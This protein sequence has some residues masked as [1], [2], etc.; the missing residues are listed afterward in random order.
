MRYAVG[1][2]LTMRLLEYEIRQHGSTIG[3]LVLEQ[4]RGFATLSSKRWDRRRAPAADCWRRTCTDRS[5]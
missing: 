4:M 3:A 5:A 1:D 2:A